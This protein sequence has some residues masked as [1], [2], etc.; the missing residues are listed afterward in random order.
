MKPN[1]FSEGWE[2]VLFALRDAS[3]ILLYF[4]TLVKLS[5]IKGREFSDFIYEFCDRMPEEDAQLIFGDSAGMA[6]KLVE[7]SNDILDFY[8]DAGNEWVDESSFVDTI[9]EN[10]DNNPKAYAFDFIYR[11]CIPNGKLSEEEYEEFVSSS[12]NGEQ[13]FPFLAS[14]VLRF[15]KYDEFLR[16]K[17]WM[18]VSRFVR[19][20]NG[21]C[22]ECGATTNLHVHHLSYDNHGCEHRHLEDLKCLCKDCHLKAHQELNKKN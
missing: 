12:I 17:Y 1:V 13:C 16:T 8:T 15:L 18:S 11:W 10:K 7:Y 19:E 22:E 4:H 3:K 9:K 6:K 5:E 21:K 20:K 2:D 14:E